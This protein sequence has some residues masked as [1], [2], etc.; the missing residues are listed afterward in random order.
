MLLASYVGIRPGLQGVGNI[1]IR[2]RL[3]TLHSHSELVFEP[4]DGVDDLMPDL[5]TDP[6]D[7][8]F[9]CGSSVFAEKMPEYSPYRSGE[10]GG[11]RLK[12]IDVSTDKWMTRKIHPAYARR[13]A[14]WFVD[15]QGIGYDYVLI[16]KYVLWMLPSDKEDLVMCSES[17]AKALGFREP[18]RIDPALLYNLVQYLGDYTQPLGTVNGLR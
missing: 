14:E 1:A 18:E 16:A 11:V 12:R 13:A 3:N 8:Q 4:G 17:V 6:I 7:N 9:W 2:F 5:T 15:N 10:T